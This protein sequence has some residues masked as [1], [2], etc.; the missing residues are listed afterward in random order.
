MNMDQ[1][2]VFLASSILLAIS[3]IVLVGAVLII[4]NLISKYWK[5]WGWRINPYDE[6]SMRYYAKE[7]LEKNNTNSN[8]NKGAK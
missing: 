1:T 3:S 6:T 8:N 7:E 5:S 2:A 4:N